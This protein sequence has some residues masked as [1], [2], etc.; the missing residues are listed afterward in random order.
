MIS[1]VLYFHSNMDLQHILTKEL[2]ML[3]MA[4]FLVLSVVGVYFFY[5]L[6]SMLGH[7]APCISSFNSQISLMQSKLSL[8]R[9]AKIADLWCGTGKAIKFF[10]SHFGSVCHGWE[11]NILAVLRAKL[12]ILVSGQK[13]VFVQYGDFTK[14]KISWFDYVYVYL[15][16]DQLADIEDRI[17]SSKSENCIIICNS[18]HFAKHEPFEI[19]KNNKVKIFLYR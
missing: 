7:R 4:I 9:W 12:S 11:V 17:F 18:F 5:F 14:Q 6:Q 19:I 3:F 8:P 2:V 10:A 15:L 1:N 13:N 16:N